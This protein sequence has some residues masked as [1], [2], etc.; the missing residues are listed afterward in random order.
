MP[1]FEELKE[2][3]HSFFGWLTDLGGEGH[4]LNHD[5]TDLTLEDSEVRKALIES[6]RFPKYYAVKGNIIVNLGFSLPDDVESDAHDLVNRYGLFIVRSHKDGS[7]TFDFQLMD[8][9]TTSPEAQDEAVTLVENQKNN[10][11]NV[12]VGIGV[13]WTFAGRPI[14]KGTI[15]FFRVANMVEGF[16]TEKE[17]HELEKAGTEA[18]SILF[19]KDKF[20]ISEART[21][22]KSHG[23]GSGKVDSPARFHRFRQFDPSQCG[24]TP[25][26]ISF[27]GSGIKAVV[28]VKKDVTPGDVHEDQFVGSAHGEKSKKKKKKLG[29]PAQ[30]TKKED[31]STGEAFS[32]EVDIFK[33]QIEEGLIYGVVY[34]PNVKDTHGDFTSKAEIENAAH[35]FLPNS[36]MNDLHEDN[37]PEV[38]VV[39][40]FIA[41]CD[42]HYGDGVSMD[43]DVVLKGSWVLVSKVLDPEL[44]GAIERGERTGYSLEGTAQKVR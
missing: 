6:E 43:R 8:E 23:K 34:A 42:F 9:G 25:K 21:W 33:A 16:T 20:S 11:R 40:S 1:N 4:T 17:F 22:L 41:P 37:N 18:Q 31:N 29:V 5:T 14:F 12:R 28:C 7:L 19:P 2:L 30:S 15:A 24:A 38:E 3:R 44:K 36:V 27:G 39:E 10:V 35:N 13:P 26:T 32:F